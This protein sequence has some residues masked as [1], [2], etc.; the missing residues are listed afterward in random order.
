MQQ[1]QENSKCWRWSFIIWVQ[2]DGFGKRLGYAA[3]P[4]FSN[5]LDSIWYWFLWFRRVSRRIQ[6]QEISFIHGSLHHDRWKVVAFETNPS[7]TL[8]FS[9]R[10]TLHR[11]QRFSKWIIVGRRLHRAHKVILMAVLMI[12]YS[13]LLNNL[14]QCRFCI[15]YFPS[16]IWRVQK[17]ETILVASIFQTEP[18]LCA[19]YYSNNIFTQHI[20][21]PIYSN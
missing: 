12:F 2:P 1:N 14:N 20:K 4:S 8:Q 16:R 17:K 11:P 9:S 13:L 7:C 18:I 10:C 6:S 5:Q 19:R 15:S 21:I 3:W